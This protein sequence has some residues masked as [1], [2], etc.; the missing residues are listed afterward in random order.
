MGNSESSNAGDSSSSNEN[1]TMSN[2]CHTAGYVAG[3]DGGNYETNQHEYWA[4]MGNY[5][6]CAVTGNVSS[7]ADGV[8][9]G[10]P[11]GD[12]GVGV[13]AGDSFYGHG[14][15]YP[16]GSCGN[17]IELASN[18]STAVPK[19]KQEAGK[20]KV[21]KPQECVES[22][23]PHYKIENNNLIYL[24]EGSS[25]VKA[26]DFWKY[27]HIMPWL[28]QYDHISSY[29]GKY[30]KILQNII[31]IEL[32]SFVQVNNTYDSEEITKLKLI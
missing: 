21:V 32:K 19:I 5:A 17:E 30:D 23:D 6:I 10:H 3:R 2:Y 20:I 14:S 28:P 31:L 18:I 16:S 11:L 22:G 1:N 24:Y 7:Y 27:K 26:D 4:D 12:L 8:A 25:W 29:N 9:D 15:D 13:N